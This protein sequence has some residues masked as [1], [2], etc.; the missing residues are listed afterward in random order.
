[1]G[2]KMEYLAI[3]GQHFQKVTAQCSIVALLD[4][5][6]APQFVPVP[7][8]PYRFTPTPLYWVIVTD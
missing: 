6:C 1:M 4:D 3:V 5:A 2:K 7:A 8:I